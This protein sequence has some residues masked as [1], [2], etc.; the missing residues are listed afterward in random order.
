M[1]TAIYDASGKIDED[2]EAA[3]RHRVRDEVIA[4]LERLDGPLWIAA[5]GVALALG[6]AISFNDAVEGDE[7]EV[8]EE[9]HDLA[10]IHGAAAGVVAARLRK[11]RGGVQ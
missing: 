8:E 3:F 11:E 7:D 9:L 6:W 10:S 5:G 1:K 4:L 2:A